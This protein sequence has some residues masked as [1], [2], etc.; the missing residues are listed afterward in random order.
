MSRQSRWRGR[1]CFGVCTLIPTPTS[2]CLSV[3]LPIYLSI[4]LS[5]YLSVYLSIYLS[6][7]ISVYL[8]I[9]L[10]VYTQQQ[11]CQFHNTKSFSP[12]FISRYM[13]MSKNENY[14]YIYK[15]YTAMNQ[16]SL[17][18]LL[19]RVSCEN[20]HQTAYDQD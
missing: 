19:L 20:I 13:G 2:V 5:V 11:G 1:T 15:Y 9:Y 6:I 10:S 14:L 12:I 7:Y 17:F 8:Y 16:T 18:P 4:Y 3:Y